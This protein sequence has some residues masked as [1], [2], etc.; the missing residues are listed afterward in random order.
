MVYTRE[1]VFQQKLLETAYSTFKLTG[2]E[3]VQPASSDKTNGKYP[4]MFL[5]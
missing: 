2:P 4:K 1:M 5:S 3:M